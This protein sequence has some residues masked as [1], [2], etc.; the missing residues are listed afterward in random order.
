MSGREVERDRLL[1]RI[2]EKTAKLEARSDLNIKIPRLQLPSEYNFRDRSI[3]S[4][5]P[6]IL[7]PILASGH[8]KYRKKLLA[9]RKIANELKKNLKSYTILRKQREAFRL[10]LVSLITKVEDETMEIDEIPSAQEKEMLRYYYYVKHGVD[11]VH[12]APIDEKVLNR[13]LSLVPRRLM[14]W[15]ETLNNTIDDIKEDFMMANKK[16]IIDF[17]LQDPAFITG[18]QDENTPFKQEKKEIGNS[19]RPAFDYA[20]F[21]MER[22][23]HVI[24]PCLSVLLDLWYTRFRKLRLIDTIELKGHEGAFDLQEFKYVFNKSIENCKDILMNQYYYA[25]TDVFLQGGKRNK[26]PDP[27]KPKRMRSF[28]NSVATIMTNQ[29]QILCLKSLYDY[30]Q[31]IIDIKVR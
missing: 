23:L 15:D 19:F 18:V 3:F 28:Y 24:N 25:V 6:K 20:K 27:G 17:V 31:Y 5:P 13:V 30:I 2:A 16:A 8:P 14:A 4:L 22:N 12:V 26:L 29:L 1:K 21:K 10:R 7:K 9:E 11:T